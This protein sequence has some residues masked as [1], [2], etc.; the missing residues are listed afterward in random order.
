MIEAPEDEF[1]AY[2]DLQICPEWAVL[3]AR[4]LLFLYCIA[5]WGAVVFFVF[6]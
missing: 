5:F 4:V 6:R 1:Q 3:L 2:R